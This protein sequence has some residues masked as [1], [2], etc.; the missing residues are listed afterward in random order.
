[1][2]ILKDSLNIQNYVKLTKKNRVFKF[3]NMNI[4]TYIQNTL[5]T[6]YKT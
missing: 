1:M 5:D 3:K 4:Y 2:H 6:A